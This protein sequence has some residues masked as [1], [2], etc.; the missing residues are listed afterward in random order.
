MIDFSLII[1]KKLYLVLLLLKCGDIEQNPGPSKNCN[2]SIMHWNINSV[3]AHNF[4]KLTLLEAFV[5][6]HKYDLICI[7]ESYLNSSISS[8]DPSSELKGYKLVRA[9]HP[10]DVK[11]G[12]SCIFYKESAD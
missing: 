9:D 10:L 12:G 2:L 5:S 11:R 4:V 1:L 7:S 6:I 3:S 8:N